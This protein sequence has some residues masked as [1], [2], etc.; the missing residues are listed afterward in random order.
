MKERE[1]VETRKD[2]K[3]EILRKKFKTEFMKTTF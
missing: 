2:R 1:Y 3:K